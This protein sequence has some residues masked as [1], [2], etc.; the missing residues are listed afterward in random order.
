L[1]HK[2]AFQ[3]QI[4]AR[5]VQTFAQNVDTA[6]NQFKCTRGDYGRRGSADPDFTAKL[7]INTATAQENPVGGGN[8]Q[9]KPV[10]G[11]PAAT[12]AEPIRPV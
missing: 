1:R 12:G 4:G 6:P 3:L 9:I 2:T 11:A 7:G 5:Q 8:R 10:P